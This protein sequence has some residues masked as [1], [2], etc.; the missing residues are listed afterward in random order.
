METFQSEYFAD[1]ENPDGAI[2]T[3]PAT[4]IIFAI[5][6]NGIRNAILPPETPIPNLEINIRDKRDYVSAKKYVTAAHWA[7]PCSKKFREVTSAAFKTLDKIRIDGSAYGHRMR[8]LMGT[9]V[10]SCQIAQKSQ[11]G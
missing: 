4:C 9:K 2:L 10:P 1:S 7:D 5:F 6:P 8:K 11:L 3:V